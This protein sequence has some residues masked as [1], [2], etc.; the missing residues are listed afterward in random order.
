[1]NYIEIEEQVNEV[2]PETLKNHEK[3]Y[4]VYL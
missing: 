4:G 1:M 3:G 2:P